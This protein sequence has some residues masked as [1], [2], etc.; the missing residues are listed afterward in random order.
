MGREQ[1][2]QHQSAEPLSPSL[3]QLCVC[4][5][6]CAL[7][8]YFHPFRGSGRR[9]AAVVIMGDAQSTQRGSRQ[10]AAAEE[11]EGREVDNP[12]TEQNTEHK[13]GRRT[14]AVLFYKV[15]LS[16]V[17]EVLGLLLLGANSSINLKMK[18]RSGLII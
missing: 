8:G 14:R 6:T 7:L 3:Q 12:Q 17:T 11:Q 10:D 5:W 16:C 18:Q 13:V 4:V 1:Q 15:M 2:Q 9:R